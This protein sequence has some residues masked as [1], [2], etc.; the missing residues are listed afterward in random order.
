HDPAGTGSF[1]GWPTYKTVTHQQMYYTW[2]ER[3]FLGG[4][5]MMV[6][7]A[8]TNEA[9]CGMGKLRDGFTCDDMDA[10]DRQIQA[11]KD[12][13]KA[14]DQKDDGLINGS[15]W[16]RIAY[17]PT[18]ARAHIRAGKMAVVLGIEVDSLFGCK[19]GVVCSDTFLRTQ[20]QKYHDLGVRHVFPIHQYD[21]AFGGAAVFRGEL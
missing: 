15:G 10:V 12:L 5:R 3:A 18:E 4:L 1:A 9:L 2:V 11:T 21:N 19:P 7:L 20:L 16:Y 13:E 8:V 17:S 6:Q 14:I